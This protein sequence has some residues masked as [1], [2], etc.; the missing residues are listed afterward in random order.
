MIEISMSLSRFVRLNTGSLM[1]SLALGTYTPSGER[2]ETAVDCALSLGYRHIDTAYSYR[3]TAPGQPSL[4]VESQ[5]GQVISDKI[6]SGKIKRKDIF[7][8]SKIPPVHLDPKDILPCL[9]ESLD[10]LKLPSVDMLLVHSPFAL[11]NKKDGNL[12]PC[13]EDG[14]LIVVHHELVDIWRVFENV[15]KKG[16]TKA[17]GVSN[18]T[19]RQM[20]RILEK[21]KVRPANLQMECH[22]FLQQDRLREYCKAKDI[23][24][25]GYAPLGAP[26]R[27]VK[28]RKN[29]DPVLLDNPVV[30]EIAANTSRTP[31]QV[32][33][34][35]L[36]QLGVVPIPKS[37]TPSRIEENMKIFDFEL[38]TAAMNNLK[39][40]G[41]RRMKYFAFHWF[42]HHP[43]YPAEG[44]D[45]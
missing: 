27:P 4:S 38:D 26:D 11:K 39:Q 40:L 9:E 13:D 35:Y 28:Y 20:D 45:F 6:K 21:G 2:V 16:L 31:S 5:V 32:L 23:V 1:P 15:L 3:I 29:D 36:L 37:V 25:T 7:V 44:E 19:A 30:K 34:R 18:F 10:N 8:T 33:L 17:I 41:D 43:E 14:N 12:Y 22:A 24:V 42:A